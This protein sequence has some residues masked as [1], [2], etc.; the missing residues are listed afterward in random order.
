[1]TKPARSV[2]ADTT[3]AAGARAQG[4]AG[5]T[6]L[7][8]FAIPLSIAGLGG[9][10]Q[11]LRTTLTAPAWPIEAL[12]RTSTGI[13]IALTAAYLASGIRR[14]RSFTA[15]REHPICRPF[16]AYIPIIGILIFSHYEQYIST[17]ARDAALVRVIALVIVAAQLLAHWLLGSL[18]AGTVHPGYFPPGRRRRLHRQHRAE[19]QRLAPRRPERVRHRH[20]LLAHHRHPDLQPPSHRRSL[21]DAPK[22]ALSVLVSPPATAGIAWFLIAGGHQDAVEYVLLGSCS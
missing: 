1:M 11:A 3:P 16:A 12:F 9:V 19:P 5:T 6:I 13:W 14:P 22:P 7:G 2:A 8:L 4:T 20:I 18:P 10:W 21:R 15:D 17:I